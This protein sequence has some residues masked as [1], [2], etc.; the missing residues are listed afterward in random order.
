[1]RP[2]R[3]PVG[4]Y[5]STGPLRLVSMCVLLV[6]IGLVMMRDSSRRGEQ[7]A[8]PAAATSAELPVVGDDVPEDIV[9]GGPTDLTQDEMANFRQE[10]AAITDRATMDPTEMPAY[11][12]LM[13]WT[14]SQ[15]WNDLSARARKDTVFTQLWDSPDEFRG[16]LVELKLRVRRV[17]TH[18]A[19]PNPADVSQVYELWGS[20]IE[21]G[22]FPYAVVLH[23]L[24]PGFPTGPA[25]DEDVLFVGY[26]LKVLG[27][28]AH[29][30]HRGAPLLIG[31]IKWS[32]P[33]PGRVTA[34]PQADSIPPAV[35][36]GMLAVFAAALGWYMLR[37]RK[38]T[39]LASASPDEASQD[40][41]EWLNDLD[42]SR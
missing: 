13:T 6:V 9:A 4:F 24:P 21:S 26:M 27:Y 39:R 14:R 31:R 11:W 15:S 41:E 1:M 33:R 36:I 25:I 2:R 40:A 37:T 42:G 8:A 20:T 35:W 3:R 7:A 17:V 22:V 19:P 30:T 16:T 12:R 28:Q 38:P 29:D 5:A 32:G 10:A 34:A 18:K 23:E